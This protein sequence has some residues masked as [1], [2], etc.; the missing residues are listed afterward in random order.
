MSFIRYQDPGDID[1][2]D[3]VSDEDNIIQVHGVH[4]KFI[5][6]HHRLY[7]ELMRGPG[8][9][10]FVQREMVATVVSGINRCHY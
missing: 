9:L 1:P 4:S 5:G 6:L 7:A 8:P 3:Q 10:S 2:A